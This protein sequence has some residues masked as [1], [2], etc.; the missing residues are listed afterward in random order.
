M[1]KIGTPSPSMAGLIPVLSLASTSS[2]EVI[3]FQVRAIARRASAPKQ[4]GRLLSIFISIFLDD[5]WPLG[6]WRQRVDPA[7]QDF[8]A[9]RLRHRVSDGDGAFFDGVHA[10]NGRL[11]FVDNRGAVKGAEDAAICNGE[12]TASHFVEA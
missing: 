11:W 7:G 6:Q 2:V 1:R 8:L 12:G 9:P 4:T 5:Q 10:E 3:T